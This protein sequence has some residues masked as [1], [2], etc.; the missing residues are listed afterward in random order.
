MTDSQKI[1]A[2]A[3]AALLIC[4]AGVYTWSVRNENTQPA[5][6]AVSPTSPTL[7]A[8]APVQASPAPSSQPSE[9]PVVYVVTPQTGAPT[10][11]AQGSHGSG[12]RTVAAPTAGP[13][14]GTST[15]I[16]E[17]SS[18]TAASYRLAPA[19]IVR[20]PNSA[21]QIVSMSISTPVVHAGQTVSGSVETSTN[22]AS[23][24]A[25]IGGYSSNLHKIG[26]GKFTL[27]YR[28]P[29]V[30]FFLKK[31]YT[32]V[33]IARNTRGDAVSTTFPITVR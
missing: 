31:T 29:W 6:P 4:A 30:P 32:V 11:V 18:K 7:A 22:V 17:Y 3:G 24:E 15:S 20:T 19:P 28:V 14:N 1:A 12:T 13:L 33:L 10:G 16:P 27:T 21:P 5:P 25:R 23:V 26:S 9:K 8:S 2:R